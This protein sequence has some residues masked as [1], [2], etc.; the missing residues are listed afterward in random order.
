LIYALVWESLVGGLVPGAQTL[1]I[2]QWSLAVV[3]RALGDSASPLGVESAVG[4]GTAAVLLTVTT[5]AATAY[6]GRRLQTLR[7]TEA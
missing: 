2:Q 1:S 7:L 6:A 5:V 4:F 3:Q